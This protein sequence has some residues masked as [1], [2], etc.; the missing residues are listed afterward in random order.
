[1][2]TIEGVDLTN[3]DRT[4]LNV[5]QVDVLRRLLVAVEP[6]ERSMG[7]DGR[8][9]VSQGQ[10]VYDVDFEN[11]LQLLR[12]ETIAVN[13]G[14]V[15]H[16]PV[17]GGVRLR[18]SS[19][20]GD[21]V[22]RQSKPYFRYQ[23]SKGMY[24][25]AAVVFG[26]PTAGNVKRVGLFDADNGIFFEQDGTGVG[27]VKRSSAGQYTADIRIAQTAFNLDRLDGTGPSGITVDW[28]RIQM[29]TM[30][31]S[32]YGGGR[33]RLGLVID[34]QTVWVHKFT[35]ANSIARAWMRTGNLPA[36]YEIFNTAGVAGNVDFM[37]WG[38]SVVIEGRFDDQRGFTFPYTNGNSRVAV[39]SRRPILSCRITP[40]SVPVTTGT[41]TGGTTSSL[42][43]SGTPWTINQFAGAY[44]LVTAGT[45]FAAGVGQVARIISNTANTLTLENPLTLG[46]GFTAAPDAT[47]LFSIG[48]LNRGQ[49]QPRSIQI[50]SD[51]NAFCELVFNSA[52]TGANFV[53][54]NSLTSPNSL[55]ERD[56]AATVSTG[57]DVIWSGYV[58]ANQPAIIPLSDLQVL[59]G[60]IL[61]NNPDI[62]SVLA[63]A[64]TGT[65]NITATL[66]NQ[67]AMS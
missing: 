59:A 9:K 31:Y 58:G 65:A 56:I 47:T 49:L 64:A 42:T 3:P 20:A 4:R 54:L 34:G 38:I 28:T 55:G 24:C 26:M 17:E 8:L 50:Q 15:A 16:M 39:T 2:A 35:H 32:W 53:K 36:R 57:G 66:I 48:Y 19:A 23:P 67:E 11:G 21:R 18:V 43:V 29:T 61:G 13:A 52:L 5:A 60:N 25:S 44:V 7:A 6:S 51:A 40:M 46:A 12:W 1:M 14:S 45:L 27:V 30:D 62:L 41:A 10:N 33:A 22:V 63:T 37:H